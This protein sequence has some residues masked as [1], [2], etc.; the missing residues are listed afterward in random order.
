MSNLPEAK[1][2]TWVETGDD[3]IFDPVERG[4]AGLAVIRVAGE[5]DPL[6]RL[7]LDEFERPG[8]D[9]LLPHLRRRHMARIDRRG[10]GG[11]QREQRGLRPVE[12]EGDFVIA[13]GRH[14][15]EI[16][17]PGLARVHPKLLGAF[18]L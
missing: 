3:R 11:E 6:G 4:T 10:A 1:A 14:L 9:R 16:A 12:P 18:A 17:V 8:A 5:L 15:F 2:S 7:E 13:L